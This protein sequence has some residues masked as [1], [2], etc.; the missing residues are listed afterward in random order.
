MRDEATS[1]SAEQICSGTSRLMRVI[2]PAPVVSR[3]R[4][5]E[6]LSTID[7]EP[8]LGP[9]LIR[10]HAWKIKWEERRMTARHLTPASL[11]GARPDFVLP[12]ITNWIDSYYARP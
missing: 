9:I 6:P 2:T 12:R 3:R 4:R 10:R 8:S 7:P 5:Q 1:S 11:P